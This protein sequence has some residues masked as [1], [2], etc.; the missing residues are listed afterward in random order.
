M[1]TTCDEIAA[2]VVSWNQLQSKVDNQDKWSQTYV[3]RERSPTRSASPTRV[4]TQTTGT[5]TARSISS[6]SKRFPRPMSSAVDSAA[7]TELSHRVTTHITSTTSQLG[8]PSSPLKY[9]AVP[10]PEADILPSLN[11]QS[12]TLAKVYGSVLQPKETLEAH[13]CAI[14]AT[15]FP[16]DATIYPDPRDPSSPSPRFLCRSCFTVNGGSKGTCPT[17]SRPVLILKAEGGFVHAAGQHWH[18]KCFN[19]EGCSKNIGDKPMVDLL[20]RPSCPDCFETCLNREPRTPKKNRDSPGKD[21][22]LDNIGGLRKSAKGGG[23]QQGS[24][25]IEELEQ[26]LGISKSRE[27]SPALEDLERRLTMISK[28]RESPTRSPLMSKYGAMRTNSPTTSPSLGRHSRPDF[29]GSASPR[30]DSPHIRSPTALRAS[31]SRDG[32][33]TTSRTSPTRQTGSP[34][35]VRYT[36]TGSPAPTEAAIEEMKQRFMRGSTPSPA[37]SPSPTKPLSL[38]RTPLRSAHSSPSLPQLSS[39]IPVLVNKPGGSK[40]PVDVDVE[41]VPPTPDLVSDFSDTTTQSS[42]PDSPPQQEQDQGVNAARVFGQGYG[43]R[44]TRGDFLEGPDRSSTLGFDDDIPEE[45]ENIATPT[46]G[47][48]SSPP[49]S[50]PS[51]SSTLPSVISL[52]EQSAARGTSSH[53]STSADASCAQCGDKLFSARHGGRYVNIPED[54]CDAQSAMKLYHPGCFRCAACAGAFQEGKEGQAIFVKGKDGPCHVE[55]IPS[56][57]VRRAPQVVT[58]ILRP[59][60]STSSITPL[61]SSPSYQSSSRYER[62]PTTAPATT[63]TFPRFGSSSACPGCRKS[64]SPMERGVVPGPQGTRWHSTCLVC[65]GKKETPKFLIRGRAEE[66]KK[67]EP[68]CGKKLD[69]AAKVDGSGGAWCRECLLLLPVGM[70]GSPQSSPVRSPV[71]PNPTGGVGHAP[72][73]MTGMTTMARQFTGIGG[74]DPALL[75][76]LTGGGLSPTRQLASSPTKQLGIGGAMR[77][78]PKSVVGMR[79]TKSV[80]EGRGMFLVRQMT[81]AG[82]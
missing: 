54:P 41:S 77:P 1:L 14:C 64:V 13:C 7:R 34:S 27:S 44:Y 76:Q 53:T 67:K 81:G 16:P 80:D 50:T 10:A 82:L 69:S 28:G 21:L 36:A 22:T 73:Q 65:G 60:A 68:G 32:T 5:V 79:N 71:I 74:G 9:S 6:P 3:S 38:A 52:I 70:R 49:K 4:D 62:P 66:R 18:K 30:L 57:K 12:S 48:T 23:S 45:D 46:P 78:R 19:C 24:P 75:R 39:N 15:D 11:P 31:P 25:A 47:K 26:R 40:E 42:G 8:R 17:C 61:S 37:R 20:G 72:L 33:P 43:S 29:I 2:P 35:P 56:E 63:T 59:V 55:C 51:K 58:P